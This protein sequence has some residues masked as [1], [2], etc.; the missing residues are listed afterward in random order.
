MEEDARPMRQSG[1]GLSE[2][3]LRKAGYLVISLNKVQGFRV[4]GP[5]SRDPKIVTNVL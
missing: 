1:P 5:K 3:P 4:Q 2:T